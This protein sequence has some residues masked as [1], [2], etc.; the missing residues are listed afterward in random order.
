MN[1]FFFPFHLETSNPKQ[2]NTS[3]VNINEVSGLPLACDQ[4][5]QTD[6]ILD[7]IME[8]SKKYV[9]EEQGTTLANHSQS[10]TDV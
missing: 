6:D 9:F 10:E 7:L 2:T 4:S 8:Q 1:L 3:M 5:T